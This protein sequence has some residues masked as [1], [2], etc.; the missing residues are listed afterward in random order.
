V[1]ARL[2]CRNLIDLKVHFWK[3]LVDNWERVP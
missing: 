1:I 3:F 2:F